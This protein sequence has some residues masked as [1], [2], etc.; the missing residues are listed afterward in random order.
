MITTCKSCGARIL[1]ALTATGKRMPID[2]EPSEKGTLFLVGLAAIDHRS[3]LEDARQAR[4]KA[5]PRYT[6]HFATCPAA[7][8]H[9]RKR[10]A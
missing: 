3:T 2:S 4:E 9:R 7:A 6:S 5:A 8:V 10:D 1:W